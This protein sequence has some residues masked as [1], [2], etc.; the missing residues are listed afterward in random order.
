MNNNLDVWAIQY[1]PNELENALNQIKGGMN[2]IYSNLKCFTKPSS[3]RWGL[4]YGKIKHLPFFMTGV[5]CIN[6]F[7]YDGV[8]F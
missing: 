1:Y 3:F 5:G 2:I 7:F 8:F 4:F 6:L